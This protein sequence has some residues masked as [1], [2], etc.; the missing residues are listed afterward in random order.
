M[1]KSAEQGFQVYVEHRVQSCD[2]FASMQLAAEKACSN[3]SFR[4]KPGPAPNG[5]GPEQN[6]KNISFC[7]RAGDGQVTLA[8]LFGHSSHLFCWV[9]ALGVIL[10]RL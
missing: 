10:I 8:R 6:R 5:L 1:L 2:G 9:V 3:R 4:L 7:S